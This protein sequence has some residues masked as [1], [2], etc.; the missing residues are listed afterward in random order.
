MS[1]VGW[2]ILKEEKTY[3]DHVLAVRDG[4]TLQV[5]IKPNPIGLSIAKGALPLPATREVADRMCYII[6]SL[7]EE[8]DSMQQS[9]ANRGELVPDVEVDIDDPVERDLRPSD[10][11]ISEEPLPV[12]AD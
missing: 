8:V 4:D 7:L 10:L 1:S 2:K 5:T 6:N 12:R 11:M 3:G 9:M